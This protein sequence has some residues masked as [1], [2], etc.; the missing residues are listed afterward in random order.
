[1]RGRGG[2]DQL[3]GGGITDL[4]KLKKG[5]HTFLV[6]ATDAAGNTDATPAEDAFTVKK[7]KKK[8]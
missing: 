1:M 6:R 5:K 8:K 7:K 2:Q 3:F 4:K